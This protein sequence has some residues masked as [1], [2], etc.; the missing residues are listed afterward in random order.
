[1][2]RCSELKPGDQVVYKIRKDGREDYADGTVVLVTGRHVHAC[3]LEGYRNRDDAVPFEDM[4]AKYD[5]EG[6]EMRFGHIHGPGTA[7]EPS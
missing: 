2:A 4:L 6:S 7:L 3:R 1:M 5:P